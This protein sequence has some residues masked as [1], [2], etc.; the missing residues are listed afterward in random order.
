MARV[1]GETE[2]LKPA[3][4][5]R[6]ERLYGR[7]Y[8]SPGGF[9][10]EQVRELAALSRECGRQLGLLIDR[11]GRPACVIVGTPAG[12]C[13]PELPRSRE[14]RGRLRG[15]RLLHTHLAG[16]PLSEEDLMDMLFLRLDAVSVLTV[17]PEGTPD[18]IQ[19]AHLL[20]PAPKTPAYAVSGA[21]PWDRADTDFSAQAEALEAEFARVLDDTR[22][23]GD[24]APGAGGPRAVLVSVGPWPRQEMESRLEELGELAR[25]AGV[26]VSGV[27]MQ[28]VRSV[29]AR[30][31]LGKGKLAELEVQ[32]LAGNA[33]MFV[34]DDELTP[35]QLANLAAITERKTIDRT[36][37]ILDIF[38]QRAATRAGKLQVELA[39]LKYALPRLSQSGRSRALDRLAG[40]IGGRGP[41]ETKLETDRRRIRERMGRLKKELDALRRQ[42][43]LSRGRRARSGVFLASL[44]GYTNAGKSSLLNALTEAQTKAQDLLFATLDA[45]IRR[46]DRANGH[47]YALADTVGFIRQL[48]KELK[49]AFQATLEELEAASLLVHVADAS[50]PEVEAQISSVEAILGELGLDAADRLLVLNKWDAVGESA[51]EALLERYPG[52]LPASALTGENLE[53]VRRTILGRLGRQAAGEAAARTDACC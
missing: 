4:L 23:T 38:A 42:R 48:P 45:S 47:D 46:L 15:I 28:R 53:A 39:Q 31:L 17:T 20:P 52:A 35:A 14:G 16:E 30:H 43:S 5:K 21:A 37:L 51:R 13:I 29:N 34:F 8:A 26:R 27:V 41:G 18:R 33:D 7:R 9:S 44:V 19:S 11:A 10:P 3:Q 24:G 36:Q 32:A 49:E 25:S 40:G 22:E 50:H 12:I 2:G 1:S 6:L